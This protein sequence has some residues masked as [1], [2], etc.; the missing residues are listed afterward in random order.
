MSGVVIYDQDTDTMS[1]ELVSAAAY[2]K[3]DPD[4][5]ELINT[6]NAEVEEGIWPGYCHHRG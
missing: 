3:V 1:N 2:T 4:V 5:A 6:R